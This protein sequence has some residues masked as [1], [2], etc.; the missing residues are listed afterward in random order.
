MCHFWYSA[1]ELKSGSGFETL[2]SSQKLRN[3]NNKGINYGKEIEG[4]GHHA[5]CVCRLSYP[6]RAGIFNKSEDNA[7]S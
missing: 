4:G 2:P 1:K 7:L 5:L 6:V 3:K